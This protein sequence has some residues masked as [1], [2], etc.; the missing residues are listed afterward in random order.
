MITTEGSTEENINHLFTRIS[1]TFDK[2]NS[3]GEL[4]LGDE[5]ALQTLFDDAS[6]YVL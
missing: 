6:Y 1:Q 3:I 2:I 5:K 4:A